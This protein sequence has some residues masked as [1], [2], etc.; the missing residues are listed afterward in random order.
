M[1]GVV[2][3]YRAYRQQP[4]D[5]PDCQYIEI[6]TEECPP[7]FEEMREASMYISQ[8]SEHNRP[9]YQ[10][11]HKADLDKAARWL[12]KRANASKHLLQF[13]AIAEEMKRA[14]T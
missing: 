10:W 6:G 7:G 2:E 4:V 9:L 12:T 3:H 5:C 14:I 8:C 1:R 11:L 13:P